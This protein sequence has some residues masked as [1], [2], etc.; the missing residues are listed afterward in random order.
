MLKFLT[1]EPLRSLPLTNPV[2]LLTRRMQQLV[3]TRLAIIALATPNLVEVRFRSGITI[4]SPGIAEIMVERQR[5][6]GEN[7]VG[8][9][10]VIPPDADV[11]VAVINV[12]HYKV[13]RSD[14]HVLGMAVVVGNMLAETLLSLYN[15]YYPPQFPFQIF[16]AEAA[17]RAW[18][19][20]IVKAKGL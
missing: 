14:R 2:G 8:I 19:E 7:D 5:L 16:T 12:D 18:M 13:N 20:E 6:G 4:D 3:E 17:G 9:I 1:I 11:D 10:V 15:A